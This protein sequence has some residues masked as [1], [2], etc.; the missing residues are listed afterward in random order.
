MDE[1]EREAEAF[2]RRT[3]TS[4]GR[5]EEAKRHTPFGVHSNYRRIDPYPL[6]VRRAH[7]TAITDVDGNDY[8][9]FSMAFGAL[10]TGHAHPVLVEAMR[11][12]LGDGTITGFEPDEVVPLARHLCERF[13]MDR[14]KLSLSGTD[15]TMFAVRLARAATGR[16]RVL[17]FEGCYHGSHD[18]LLVSVKPKATGDPRRPSPIAA[19]K[20]LP[21]GWAEQVVVAPFND[22][23]ATEALVRENQDDLATIILEPIPM[24]MGFVLPQ[25]GFLE[26]LRTLA[27]DT[28]AVLVFDEVKTCGKFYGGAEEA[29]GVRPDLKVLG[30]ALGGGFPIAAVGGRA[31][32]MEAVAPGV[33]AHAG[34]F[35]S[36]P[37][38]VA[39]ALVTLT[40]ILTRLA[41]E[42]AASRGDRLAVGYADVVRDHRL[43]T[44]V[45]H[46]GISGT[47]HFTAKPVVDWRS[48][49][50][51]DVAK[52]WG[53]FTAML[54]RGILPMA[55]GPDEQWT[56][57]VQHTDDDVARHVEVFKEVAPM[58][59][60]FA[61][62]M[63]VVEAI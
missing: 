42:D 49:Q 7:G 60:R 3:P 13:L 15:A 31:D 33:V 62:E 8:A 12:R 54:N 50:V 46:R 26:G 10:V 9:D 24:N 22:L 37:V 20:G 17:K 41:M 21:P 25:P 44:V 28:G 18:G 57:S 16:S 61:G 36:N 63:P 43:P 14:V 38:S 58:I 5:F 53:Y 6:Y 1:L 29:F 19:T 59:S 51:V 35:N 27:D 55:T 30:K 47:V 45:Q 52:W 2:Q 34:T 23:D 48:F 56:V 39:A 40:Q 32:L 11:D 4:A